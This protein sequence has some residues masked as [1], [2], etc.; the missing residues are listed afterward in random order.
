MRNITQAAL[1]KIEKGSIKPSDE[2]KFNIAKTL[3]FPA[4][5]FH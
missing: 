2:T 5:F 3:N 1:S 4:R